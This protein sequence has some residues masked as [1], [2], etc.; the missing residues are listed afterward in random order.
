MCSSNNNN[1]GVRNVAINNET[2]CLC[3][4]DNNPISA[5]NR[6]SNPNCKGVNNALNCSNSSAVYPFFNPRFSPLLKAKERFSATVIRGAVPCK[7]FW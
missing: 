3:P 5:S 1:S 4:P 2:A 7:G 6:S